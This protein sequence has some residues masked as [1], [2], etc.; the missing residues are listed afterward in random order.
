MGFRLGEK[1]KKALRIGSKV[2][3][4][5]VALAGA[6]VLGKKEVDKASDTIDKERASI[7]AQ[8]S[9][10]FKELVDTGKNRGD[11]GVFPAVIPGGGGGTATAPIAGA[12]STTRARIGAGL[13]AGADVFLADSKK[14]AFR[15]GI[16]GVRSV[17]SATG[18]KGDGAILQQQADAGARAR[19]R[20]TPVARPKP[21]LRQSMRSRQLE[22]L[23]V[24]ILEK[25]RQAE[26]KLASERNAFGRRKRR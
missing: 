3:G 25:Q 10:D 16:T 24:P 6:G 18:N 9:R 2:G 23:S 4:I 11:I 26:R 20:G 17:L 5:A 8:N 14:G 1:G 12:V 22:A 7:R 19:A 21:Q 13:G 15:A